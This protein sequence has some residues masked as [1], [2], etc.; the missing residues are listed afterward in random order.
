MRLG[1]SLM[2][3]ETKIADK[4][5]ATS[6]VALTVSSSRDRPHQ[7]ATKLTQIVCIAVSGAITPKIQNSTL[8]QS[9]RTATT[10]EQILSR[11]PSLHHRDP[12]FPN[13]E[14]SPSINSFRVRRLFALI[15]A[16]NPDRQRYF[17]QIAQQSSISICSDYPL[18]PANRFPPQKPTRADCLLSIKLFLQY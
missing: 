5:L 12:A 11:S 17:R 1:R 6:A 18:P 8:N 14:E 2:T 15:V 13:P 10:A 16:S 7:N 4:Y 3:T 9:N